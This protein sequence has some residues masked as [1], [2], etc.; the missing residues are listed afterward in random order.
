MATGRVVVVKEYR[1]PF[2]IE[3]YSVPVPS[4]TL[5]S[6]QSSSKSNSSG[7]LSGRLW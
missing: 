7:M 4:A 2:V 3:E 6:A 1:E 5:H